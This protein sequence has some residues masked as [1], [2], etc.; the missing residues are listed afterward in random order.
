MT[1]YLCCPPR[2]LPQTEVSPGGRRGP[3]SLKVSWEE[4]EGGVSEEDQISSG[5]VP[6]GHPAK[7]QVD[8]R[9]HT[10]PCCPPEVAPGVSVLV[11]ADDPGRRMIQQQQQRSV[12]STY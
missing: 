2:V 8:G 9:V 7:V 3:G 4:K 12:S 11:S 6:G 10:A 1:P 5:P